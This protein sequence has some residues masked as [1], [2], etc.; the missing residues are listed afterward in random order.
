MHKNM[1]KKQGITLLELILF[2]I[3]VGIALPPLL[4]VAS[5]AVQN[6]IT[7]EIILKTTNLA[8]EKMEEIK[9]LSF[10][11]ITDSSGQFNGPFQDYSFSISVGCISPPDY[12][13]THSCNI[14]DNY[15]RVTVT[16]SNSIIPE[17]DSSLVTII[18]RR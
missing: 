9:A 8:E 13:N 12:E 1:N 11:D 6:T 3:I 2:M 14:T 18:S 10:D 4:M 15:K 5:I 16:V 17:I 7:E